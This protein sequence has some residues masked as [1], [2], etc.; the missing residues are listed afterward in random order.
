MSKRLR[1]VAAAT[2]GL[3][4]ILVIPNTGSA[5]DL[6][7]TIPMETGGRLRIQLPSGRIEI[8]SHDESSVELNGRSSGRFRFEVDESEDEI[9]VHGRS[10]GFL[11]WFSGKVSIH[12]RVPTRFS[13][14]LETGGGR[15]DIE[16]IHGDVRAHTS[17][18]RI[19]LE[20]TR[21]MWTSR[22]LAAG[23]RPRRLTAT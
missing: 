22:P 7:A 13:L 14:D 15:I 21:A 6:E 12:V 16:D 2:L 4:L 1:T 19:G 18:G 17:G 8:D 9:F 20:Q 5:D 10:D 11:G 3:L 23:S